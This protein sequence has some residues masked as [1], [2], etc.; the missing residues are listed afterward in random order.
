VLG[1]D[2]I[3]QH[4]RGKTSMGEA[5]VGEVATTQVECAGSGNR[6]SRIRAGKHPTGFTA[7]QKSRTGAP[8]AS[9]RAQLKISYIHQFLNLVKRTKTKRKIVQANLGRVDIRYGILVRLLKLLDDGILLTNCIVPLK[10]VTK[11]YGIKLQ[12]S[13]F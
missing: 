5:V 6:R 7:P 8:C 1:F 13:I 12:T 11:S 4:E 2:F 10:C 3:Q 9:L